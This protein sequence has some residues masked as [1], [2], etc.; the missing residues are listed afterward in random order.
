MIQQCFVYCREN[1]LR[2]LNACLQVVTPVSKDFWLHN[3]HYA[4]GLANGCILCQHI[5][6][7]HDGQLWGHAISNLQNTTPLSKQTTF[8]LVLLAPFGQS[9]QALCSGFS[10]SPSK[11]DHAFVSLYVYL[12]QTWFCQATVVRRNTH[13]S[14][15]LKLQ[16]LSSNVQS[17]LLFLA[18]HSCPVDNPNLHLQ[19]I[20]MPLT[21]SKVVSRGH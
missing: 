10:I 8:L 14:R 2:C 13:P 19:L 1:S 17:Q 4:I 11:R 12:S 6:I 9:I 15:L 20:W 7:L 16:S 18:L 21:N 3:W 5:S